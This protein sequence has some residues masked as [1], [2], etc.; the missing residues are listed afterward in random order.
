MIVNDVH[1]SSKKQNWAT[2]PDLF[3]ALH[4]EFNFTIDVCAENWNAKLP[5]FWTEED[6]ALTQDWS[7]ERCFMNPPY[8][9][10]IK[11][12]VKKAAES[13]AE[14]VVALVPARTDTIYFHEFIYPY[15]EIRFIR[16]RVHFWTEEGA[17]TCAPF[18][19]MIVIWRGDDRC[20]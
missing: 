9:R 14:L 7:G 13:G 4:N 3:A 1:Y 6:N 11:D 16:G 15:A 8:G 19:S 2:P 5:R 18:P 12:F 17:G 10:V 20:L